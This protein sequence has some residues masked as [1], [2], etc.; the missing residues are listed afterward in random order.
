MFFVCVLSGFL[1]VV[2]VFCAYDGSAFVLLV[3]PY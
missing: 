1:E 2:L 3:F